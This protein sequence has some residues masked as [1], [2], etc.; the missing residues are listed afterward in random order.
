[1]L[2]DLDETI[3]QL[4]IRADDLDPSQVDIS[5]AIPNREW[6]DK[7]SSR[8]TIN[9][10]LFDIHERR[11]LRE[12]GWQLEGRGGRASARRSPPI[13]FEITYLVTAWTEHVEDEH[14]LLWRALEALMDQPV[15]PQ[16][17]L[18]GSLAGHP[19]P[20]HTSVAQLEGVLKSPGEFW[21]AL[22]NQIKPSLT[23]SVILGRDRAPRPTEA[24]PVR[25]LG[26][27]LR[28]PEA[29]PGAAFAL[30][31]IFRLP[32]GA[33]R[34]GVAVELRPIDP[35]DGTIGDLA[36]TSVSDAAGHLRFAVAPG[37]YQ[38][39]A[40]I[41]GPQRRSLIVRAEADAPARGYSDVVRDQAGAPIAGVRVEAE[42]LGLSAVSDAEGRFHLD[43]P[44]GRHSIRLHLDGYFERRQVRVGDHLYR[45]ALAYGGVAAAPETT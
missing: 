17:L 39:A 29:A 9:C 11:L 28:L 43:L 44:P 34:A 41:D 10:Y 31:D 42:G 23:Y 15:L 27:R 37:R 35:A 21:T 26:L 40:D 25:G 4:L 14:F 16:D 1:M 45:R 2:N 19:W 7:L 20:V 6:S 36:A 32:A 5:F 38:A 12:E 3:R 22:E 24:P 8:P 13:F 33:P 18:H 30:G